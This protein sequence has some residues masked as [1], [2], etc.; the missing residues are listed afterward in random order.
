MIYIVFTI[1]W[2][3]PP[4]HDQQHFLKKNE[5]I[6]RRAPGYQNFRPIRVL[7]FYQISGPGAAKNAEGQARCVVLFCVVFAFVVYFALC[8]VL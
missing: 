7:H 5:K 2:P 4:I 1:S 8:V 6:S 3:A